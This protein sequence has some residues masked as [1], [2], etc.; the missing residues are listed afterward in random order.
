MQFY[1]VGAIFCEK[2]SVVTR[3]QFSFYNL[4]LTISKWNNSKLFIEKVLWCKITLQSEQRQIFFSCIGRDW[5]VAKISGV[6]ENLCLKSFF[7]NICKSNSQTQKTVHFVMF[8]KLLSDFHLLGTAQCAARCALR[9]C[10]NIRFRGYYIKVDT[11]YINNERD[12]IS[13]DWL[14]LRPHGWV[15]HL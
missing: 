4:L 13:S 12:K 15:V 2:F 11:I 8:V 9:H 14:A 5:N 3:V 7:L 6:L 10:R 1:N